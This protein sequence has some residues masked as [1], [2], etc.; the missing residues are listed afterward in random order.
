LI[1][2]NAKATIEAV[3]KVSSKRDLKE[4][5]SIISDFKFDSYNVDEDEREIRGTINL[6]GGG[7][8]IKMMTSN[9]KIEIK[10]LGK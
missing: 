8:L 7:K 3:I 5:Y 10:K 6:N 2:E 9:S 4:R 1:S